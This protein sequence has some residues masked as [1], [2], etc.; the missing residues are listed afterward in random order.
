MRLDNYITEKFALKS[1]SYA[2]NLIKKGSV[3]VDGEACFKPAFEVDD[4]LNIQ[5]FDDSYASVG[6]Y[7]L[8]KALDTF[9]IDVKD[10]VC[11][12][13][14][15][16]NGGFTDVLLRR[17][18][19]RVY[20]VDVAEC[21]LPDNLRADERV[22]VKERLNAK[23]ITPGDIGEA[24]DIA[25][26]DVSFISLTYV[27]GAVASLLKEGGKIV[28]LIKPQFEL[29]HIASKNGIVTRVE[30]RLQ[31]VNRVLSSLSAAGLYCKRLTSV[32]LLYKDKN[33]EYLA[34]I[35]KTLSADA[36]VKL[37]KEIFLKID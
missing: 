10:L 20:A 22:I 25:T 11:A 31:A 21:Q 26:V 37:N 28:A 35:D 15:A 16:S 5:I 36:I 7:K 14:G 12:D 13:I 2:Q 9:K 17:D 1:R 23:N 3:T 18:A 24:V 34:L 8:V 32:P 33:V 29:G 30:D 4:S 19:A 6:A 27:L